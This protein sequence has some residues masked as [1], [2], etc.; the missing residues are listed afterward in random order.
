MQAQ[1]RKELCCLVLLFRRHGWPNLILRSLTTR[2]VACGMRAQASYSTFC[3]IALLS[4]GLG[5]GPLHL[6]TPFK[7]GS[8]GIGSSGMLER[9]SPLS[10]WIDTAAA[11]DERLSP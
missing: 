11:P 4:Q 3:G 7:T 9:Y 6:P 8:R 5:V 1:G 10:G 2:V